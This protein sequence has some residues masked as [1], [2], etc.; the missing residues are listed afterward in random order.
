M[1]H[2]YLSKQ[3]SVTLTFDLQNL[4]GHK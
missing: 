4:T 2:T 1:T 3:T